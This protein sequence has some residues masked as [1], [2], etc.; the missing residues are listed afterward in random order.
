MM[1]IFDRAD[2]LEMAQSGARIRWIGVGI[3]D[4][5]LRG[6]SWRYD[7]LPACDLGLQESISENR[8]HSDRIEH[9]DQQHHG[10]DQ[11]DVQPVERHRE[12][13]LEADPVDQ[14]QRPCDFRI[15]WA[16][17]PIRSARRWLFGDFLIHL[18][19]L[20]DLLHVQGLFEEK[21]STDCGSKKQPVPRKGCGLAVLPFRRPLSPSLHSRLAPFRHFPVSRP[22]LVSALRQADSRP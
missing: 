13:T 12:H 3:K 6:R 7:P 15:P 2:M 18:F 8:D 19:E 20:I 11:I 21:N 5:S 22:T 9:E 4:W 16:P 10:V 1:S 17:E 14:R